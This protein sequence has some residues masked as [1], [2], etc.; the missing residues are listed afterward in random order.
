MA[1]THLVFAL[2]TKYSVLYQVVLL[3]TKVNKTV[4]LPSD[5]LN[6]QE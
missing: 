4:S 5:A 6:L 3:Y 2:F 1:K